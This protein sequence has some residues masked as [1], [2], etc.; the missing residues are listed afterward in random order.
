MHIVCAKAGAK[1][2]QN[3]KPQN[4]ETAIIVSYLVVVID[5]RGSKIHHIS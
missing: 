4:L 5:D 1:Q 3:N 2:V